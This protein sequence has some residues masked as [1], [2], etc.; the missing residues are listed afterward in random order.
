MTAPGTRDAVVVTID[1]ESGAM[2]TAEHP[3]AVA[4]IATE[5]GTVVVEE[6]RGTAIEEV[7]L[8]APDGTERWRVEADMAE[9]ESDPAWVMMRVTDGVLVSDYSGSALTL[10][11]G[12]PATAPQLAGYEGYTVEQ[13]DNGYLLHTASGDIQI[14]PSELMLWLDDDLGGPVVL[15]QDSSGAITASVRSDG[16]ELWQLVDPQC[17]PWMRLGGS[18]VIGC[19]GEDGEGVAAALDELTGE[20]RWTADDAD[21]P[22]AASTDAVLLSSGDRSAIIAVDPRNGQELWSQPL[23]D[24]GYGNYVTIDGGMLVASDSAVSLLTW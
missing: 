3:A 6:R 7:V 24:R 22:M 21:W 11:T 4:A 2:T 10:S 18:I 1:T 23:P 5:R 15:R 9:T 16:T 19:W 20:E 8:V 13:T 17:Y 12:E 14:G